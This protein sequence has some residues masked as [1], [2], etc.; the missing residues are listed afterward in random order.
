MEKEKVMRTR[1][2]IYYYPWGQRRYHEGEKV[3]HITEN[4]DLITK[5]AVRC[6][7]LWIEGKEAICPH[8]SHY[9]NKYGYFKS[10]DKA[11]KWAHFLWHSN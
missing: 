8:L 2:Q 6:Y 3:V 11:K 1:E 5:T 10:I 4:G 7:R 9:L